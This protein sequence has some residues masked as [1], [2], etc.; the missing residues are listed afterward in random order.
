M[1]FLVPV[2]SLIICF[3]RNN[4]V[5]L[6]SSQYFISTGKG[7]AHDFFLQTK[8]SERQILD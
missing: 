8:E 5:L 1:I 3:E 6:K 7:E 4:L 2:I